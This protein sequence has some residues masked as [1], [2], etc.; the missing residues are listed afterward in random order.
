VKR[1]HVFAL[2]RSDGGSITVEMVLLA[3]VVFAFFCFVIGVG[4]LDEAHGQVVGA[5]RDAARAAS[6]AR[7]PAEAVAAANSTA[8]A[9]LT[10]TGL[11]CR[12]VDV[13][14]ATDQFTPGGIVQVTVSCTTD[15]SDVTVSGL[16]G[17]KT[18][19]ASATAP[20]D[21]FRGVGA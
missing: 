8:H 12:Q 2:S 20:L 16:P 17:A 13:H 18:L 10:S 9:D 6:N 3:P 1:R 7:T 15:L 21:T 19:S 14:V 11:T 4:R 5:A